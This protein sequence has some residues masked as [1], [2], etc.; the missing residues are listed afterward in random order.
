MYI[1]QCT[2]KS[3]IWDLDELALEGLK[4]ILLSFFALKSHYCNV[5]DVE[6][7]LSL[8]THFHELQHAQLEMHLNCV[9]L[10]FSIA[11]A[12]Q[13]NF[14]MFYMGELTVEYNNEML[15]YTRIIL[16]DSRKCLHHSL[17]SSEV[18]VNVKCDLIV[19][20]GPQ[21]YF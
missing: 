21:F 16:V 17:C 15:R 5:K 12:S 2:S 20:V 6:T 4:I 13:H 8:L 7:N 19:Q 10:F 1:P 3:Y 18:R 11:S 9:G 14:I